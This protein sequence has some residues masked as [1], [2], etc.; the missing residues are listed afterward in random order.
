VTDTVHYEPSTDP[1][2]APEPDAGSFPRRVVDTFFSP[3]ALFQRF[4]ARPPWIDVTILAIVLGAIAFALIPQEVWQTTMEEAMRQRGQEL[5]PGADPE[6]MASMQRM[7][8]LV[9]AA[10]MPWIILAIQAGIMVLLFTVIMGGKA[11]FRQ[12]LGV[13]AHATLI[14]AVG[15][16][17]SLPIIIRQG[18]M[19]Q[20]ITLGAL[21]SGMDH[22]SFVYQFLNA[23]NVFLIWQL[24]VLGLG[25]SALNRRIGAGTA[26]GV[27]LGVYACIAAAIAAAT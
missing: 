12:Y 15:Q 9:G 2:Y 10:I 25:A 16:L 18:V 4:G 17:A 8:G 13:A 24:V 20:G 1:A 7:F 14:G 27:L 26:I 19:S 3:V 11:T 22:E 6:S 21:V 23:W 5:P